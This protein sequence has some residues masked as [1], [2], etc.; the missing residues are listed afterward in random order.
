MWSRVFFFF[1][2]K[3]AVLAYQ[4]LGLGNQQQCD[5]VNEIIFVVNDQFQQQKDNKLTFCTYSSSEAGKSRP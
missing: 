4:A 2:P 3:R 5:H 1:S